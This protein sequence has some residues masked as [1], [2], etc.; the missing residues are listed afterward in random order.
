MRRV[1]EIATLEVNGLSDCSVKIEPVRKSPRAPITAVTITWWR[2][3]GDA[4]R[5]TLRELRQPKVGRMARLKGTVEQV[6]PPVAAV[7]A[8]TPERPNGEDDPPTLPPWP[9]V[10]HYERI[11][12]DR[13]SGSSLRRLLRRAHRS[14]SSF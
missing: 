4:Y 9:D 1:L 7:A 5:D 14:R 6:G 2:K 3:E 12:W 8:A 10:T 11:S 13:I